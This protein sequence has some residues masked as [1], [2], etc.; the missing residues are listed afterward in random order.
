MRIEACVYVG[1]KAFWQVGTAPVK[2]LRQSVPRL[3]T[4]REIKR[5]VRDGPVG[6]GLTNGKC[7]VALI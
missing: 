6:F 2:I 4:V 1:G 7:R 3:Y 5:G